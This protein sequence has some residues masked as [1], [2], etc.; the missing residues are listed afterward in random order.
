MEVKVTAVKA[1]I[2]GN[3]TSATLDTT[4][5]PGA[6]AARVASDPNFQAF[7]ELEALQDKVFM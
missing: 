2:R 3:V 6:R 4:L 1:V 5:R 7:L